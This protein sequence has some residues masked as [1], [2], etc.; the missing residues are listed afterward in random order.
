MPRLTAGKP[1]PK[2]SVLII[3]R[4]DFPDN[5]RWPLQGKFTGISGR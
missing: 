1:L 4:E 2:H 5:L 3:L